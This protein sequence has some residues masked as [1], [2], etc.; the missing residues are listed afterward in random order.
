MTREQFTMELGLKWADLPAG[1]LSRSTL[2]QMQ[3]AFNDL[4]IDALVE[5]PCGHDSAQNYV[6]K[7]DEHKHVIKCGV[8]MATLQEY[9]HGI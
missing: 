8:C 2:R 4:H 3:H 7:V 1:E 5:A 9:D 6:Q